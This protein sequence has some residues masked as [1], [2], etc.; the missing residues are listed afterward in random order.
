MKRP[1]NEELSEHLLD[2]DEEILGN[3]YSIDDAEKM[4]QFV[5]KHFFCLL[6]SKLIIHTNP[7]KKFIKMW[8]LTCSFIHFTLKQR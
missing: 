2:V 6:L 8:F 4:K 5:L 1:R 3:A 7:P